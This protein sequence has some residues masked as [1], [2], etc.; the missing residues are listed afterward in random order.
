VP[1]C[2]LECNDS[3]NI[4]FNHDKSAKL[5]SL[6]FTRG[7]ERLTAKQITAVINA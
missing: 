7:D 4:G 6:V 1:Y 2:N 5:L 3:Q